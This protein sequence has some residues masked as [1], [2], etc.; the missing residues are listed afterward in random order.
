MTLE[1][2][3]EETLKTQFEYPENPPDRIVYDH[4]HKVPSYPPAE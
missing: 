3:V 2:M 4:G 1:Q